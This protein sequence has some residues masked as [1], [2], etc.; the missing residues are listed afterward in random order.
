M[1]IAEDCG[2]IV[3]IGR[4]VVDEA[5][6]ESRAWLNAGTQPVPMAVNISAVEF[7]HKGFVEDVLA[8]LKRTSL[9]PSAL[10]LELTES[11]PMRD[12]ES[13]ADML[14]ELKA[15]GYHFSRPVTAMEFASLVEAS[16]DSSPCAPCIAD[17]EC[18]HS[19]SYVL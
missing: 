13:S 12:A 3:P 19:H 6:R 1:P 14:H 7:R 18:D 5:C 17:G 9:D 16:V 11:V 8:S 15:K 2:L 10:E 4:W